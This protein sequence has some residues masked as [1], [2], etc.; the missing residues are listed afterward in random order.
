LKAIFSLPVDKNGSL[1]SYEDVVK[2]LSED[3]LEYDASL[4]TSSG[5]RELAVFT[6]KAKVGSFPRLHFHQSLISFFFY[7][8]ASNYEKAVEWLQDILWNTQFTAER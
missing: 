3:T 4:G 8:Q 5:F 1:V 7:H 2:G 6:L